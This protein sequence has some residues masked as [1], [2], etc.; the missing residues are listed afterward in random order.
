MRNYII[1]SLMALSIAL[2]ANATTT[3][4]R[5]A[6]GHFIRCPLAGSQVYGDWKSNGYKHSNPSLAGSL[7]TIC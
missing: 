2:P 1:G 6:H 5:D 3:R 7:F 4:C